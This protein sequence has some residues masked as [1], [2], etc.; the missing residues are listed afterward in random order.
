[1]NTEVRT[2][3]DNQG[4]GLNQVSIG[5]FEITVTAR[6]SKMLEN[7]IV[8]FRLGNSATGAECTYTGG[9]GQLGGGG[10]GVLTANGGS[11]RWAYDPQTKVRGAPLSGHGKTNKIRR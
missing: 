6:S 10:F 7:V 1:M 2:T 9:G 5:T 3:G 4:F 8:E 11:V